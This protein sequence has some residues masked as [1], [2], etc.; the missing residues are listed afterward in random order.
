MMHAKAVR[1]LIPIWL[2]AYACLAMAAP[3]TFA[4]EMRDFDIESFLWSGAAGLLGGGLRTI[5]SMAGDKRALLDIFK[6]SG[7][8]MLAALMAGMVCYL[9]LLGLNSLM[10]TYL[11]MVGIP[12]D[13][14]MAAL[15]F[16][17]YSRTGFFR[18]FDKIGGNIVDAAERRILTLKGKQDPAAPSSIAA[19][20]E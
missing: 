16:A 9:A 3:T 11:G 14:R 19:P 20:L 10:V 13:L 6:E 7:K 1:R 8:D 15:W 12:R 5:V 2:L 18:R 17:G 4:Q